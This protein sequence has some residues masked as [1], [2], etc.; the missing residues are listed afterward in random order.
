[1][2]DI[3]TSEELEATARETGFY[4]RESKVKPSVLFDLLMYD[5]NSGNSKSL[6]QLSIEARSEH[7]IGVTKQGIDKKPKQMFLR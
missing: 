2:E 4:R 5:M 6:N 7:D 1:M 3:F